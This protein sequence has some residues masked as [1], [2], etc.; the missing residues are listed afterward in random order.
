MRLPAAVIRGRGWASTD[1]AEEVAALSAIEGVKFVDGSLNLIAGVPVWL[2]PD[3]AVYRNG[4]QVFWRA[5]LD[6]LSVMIGRWTSGCPAHV[7]EIFAGVRLRDALNLQDGDI[8]NLDIPD[9]IVS[10]PGP[11]L[12]DRLIWN[13]FWKFRERLIYRDGFYMTLMHNRT[14]RGYAWRSMQKE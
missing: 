12:R 14:V 4:S 13:L 1:R 11:S 9:E 8:V 3:S 5:S 2:A 7:F 10:S 6:G